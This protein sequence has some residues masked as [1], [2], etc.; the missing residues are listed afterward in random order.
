[1]QVQKS[2]A[3]TFTVHDSGS[4]ALHPGLHH[5][6]NPASIAVCRVLRQQSS[7]GAKGP[8]EEIAA[9]GLLPPLAARP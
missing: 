5:S 9:A 4:S 1:M 7:P 3:I 2:A 6:R 8:V